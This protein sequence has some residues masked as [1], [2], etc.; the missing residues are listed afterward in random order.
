MFCLQYFNL[1]IQ[2]DREST[3]SGFIKENLFD[4]LSNKFFSK[5]K[6]ICMTDEIGL[7]LIGPLLCIHWNC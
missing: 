5:I 1:I 3:I 7:V 4:S 6:Y 2:L